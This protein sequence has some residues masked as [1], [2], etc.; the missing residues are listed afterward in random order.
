MKKTITF[1]LSLMISM[2]VCG[3]QQKQDSL[4][5]RIEMD[6]TTWKHVVSLIRENF[7]ANTETGRTML[8][9]ILAPLYRYAFVPR[10]Q[11]KIPI[12]KTSSPADKPKKN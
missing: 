3:Q 12:E 6:S 5:M 7:N 10:E 1:A 11:P 2:A 4:I 8:S 9:E